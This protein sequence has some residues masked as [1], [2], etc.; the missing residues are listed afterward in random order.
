MLISLIRAV[1]L[2][3][4]VIFSVRVMGKRQIGELQPAELVITILISQIVTVP[5]QDNGFPLINTVIPVC[6]L[7]SLEIIMSIVAM[8]LPKIRR[9]VSG[10][11]KIIIRDGK[12][13]QRALRQLRLTV[14]DL[15]EALRQKDVFD[16]AVIDYAIIETNG[17]L[18]VLLNPESQNATS[19]MVNAVPED[20]G[21][22]C[23][24]VSDGKIVR[25]GLRECSLSEN[26]IFRA[27]AKSS[28]KITQ[29]LLMTADKQGNFIFVKKDENA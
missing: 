21:L 9:I 27:L 22:T 11:P 2:Y 18:S 6:I 29:I 10:N 3:F 25:N 5:M 14:D 19:G 26:D 16:L 24:V 28:L 23:T 4:F 17:K 20:I 8:K 15:L 7:I 13:D 1:I 12:I